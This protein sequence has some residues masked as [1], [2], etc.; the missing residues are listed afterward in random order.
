M[1][2]PGLQPDGTKNR[3]WRDF[4]PEYPS[5]LGFIDVFY[6]A[7]LGFGLVM[8][9]LIFDHYFDKHG[10]DWVAFILLLF[11]IN[12]LVGD[13]VD[14]RLFSHEYKYQSLKRFWVD[15]FI[16]AGFFGAFVT[17]Y[18][19]SPYFLVVMG[20]AF[21]LG[22]VWCAMLHF[23]VPEV[24]PLRLPWAITFTHIFAGIILIGYWWCLRFYQHQYWS[25]KL[26]VADALWIVGFYVIWS[27]VCVGGEWVLNIP[28]KEA[29]LFPH[30]PFGRLVRNSPVRAA[31][32]RIVV[33]GY[34]RGAQVLHRLSTSVQSLEKRWRRKT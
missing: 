4:N 18:H 9:G 10:F 28:S 13:Y 8:I 27:A 12:Y 7:L 3:E 22:G 33:W 26:T 29:D 34:R 1:A 25:Q 20:S 31:R 2:T 14:S 30:F 32:R 15:L 23:E 17:G 19:G 16:G 24:R 6:S 21:L 5:L 11:A